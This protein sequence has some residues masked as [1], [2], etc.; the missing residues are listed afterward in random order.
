MA[1]RCQ[2][3]LSS[4]AS[5]PEQTEEFVVAN[6]CLSDLLSQSAFAAGI[7]VRQGGLKMDEI[8][9]LNAARSGGAG[10]VPVD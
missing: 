2:C 10:L 3:I 7:E 8:R 6:A 4:S 5:D 9:A 1:S